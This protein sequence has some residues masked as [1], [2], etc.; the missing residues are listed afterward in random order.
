MDVG[1]CNVFMGGTLIANV[2]SIHLIDIFMCQH[3]FLFIGIHIIVSLFIVLTFF[4]GSNL[5]ADV[6]SSPQY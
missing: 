5:K 4:Q 6:I 1:D 2:G 3:V